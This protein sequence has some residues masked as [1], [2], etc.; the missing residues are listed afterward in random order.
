M[1]DNNS[2]FFI[3]FCFIL[4]SGCKAVSPPS[5]EEQSIT[6]NRTM[7]QY[8]INQIFTNII[9]AAE[10]RPLAFIDI[11]SVLGNANSSTTIGGTLGFSS[12]GTLW[13]SLGF[14]DLTAAGI[15]PEQMYSEGFTFTQ[16]SMDNATFWNV[17][18]TRIPIQKLV[19]FRG[20]NFQLSTKLN[21]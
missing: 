11:P 13:D 12:G 2:K 15:N 9:R 6:Y 7:E 14:S 4:L 18:M 17:F 3:L 19:Y 8:K 16:S 5:F 20:D 1:R 21:A 10:D